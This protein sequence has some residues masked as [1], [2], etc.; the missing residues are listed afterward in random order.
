VAVNISARQFQQKDFLKRI[1]SILEET[2]LDPGRLELELTET[3]IM[4]NASAAAD[5]LGQLRAFGMGV[6]IDDFGT[7]YS[8]L[9]RLREMPVELVKI[10]RSFLRGVPGDPV[11]EQMALAALTLVQTLGMTAVAEGIETEE[12]R[13]FL[14]EHGCPLGQGYHLA[15]PMPAEEVRARLSRDSARYLPRVRR[16]G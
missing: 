2:G 6:A 5:L 7:G 15:A 10:D 16:R 3:S 4:E 12:Q 13:R 9:G 8:S 14:L 11:G 1:V